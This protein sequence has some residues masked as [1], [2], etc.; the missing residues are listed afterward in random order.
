MNLYI[1][2]LDWK[3]HRWGSDLQGEKVKV[4]QQAQER[5]FSFPKIGHKE[6]REQKQIRGI[7]E[8]KERRGQEVRQRSPAKPLTVFRDAL[9]SNS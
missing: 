7:R 1:F 6:P 2:K 8:T 9:N 4:P 3:R 5:G